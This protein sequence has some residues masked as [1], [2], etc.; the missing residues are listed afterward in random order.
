MRLFIIADLY[1]YAINII[2][3]PIHNL[4]AAEFKQ[5]RDEKKEYIYL[6]VRNKNEW[7]QG[8]FEESMNLPLH[9]VPLFI[10]EKIPDKNA[11]IVIGCALGGRSSIGAQKLQ[12]MGYNTIYNLTCGYE[13]YFAN[14]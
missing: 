6:D 3:M 8:H 2:Y 12:N 14:N 1:F 4:S 11:T 10:E 9:L 13:G 5:W 7:D